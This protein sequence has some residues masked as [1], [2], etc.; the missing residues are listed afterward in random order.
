VV[1][2]R[3]R[4]WGECLIRKG[5]LGPALDCFEELE[6]WDNLI[7]CYRLLDKQAQ[8]MALIKTRL[9]ETP[10][11]PRLW[12]ALGDLT[13]DD[14]H[15]VTAWERSN[16]RHA[17]AKRSLARTAAARDDWE[18]AAGHWEAALAVNALDADGWFAN[19]YAL[20]KSS[21]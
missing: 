21:R 18:A 16:K 5:I 17:R 19:G 8:A 1:R 11:D 12:C 13:K 2:L 3:G 4:Q 9:Q 7:Y 14:S 15:F 10:D 20:L 6:L